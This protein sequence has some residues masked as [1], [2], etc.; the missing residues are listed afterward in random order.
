MFVISLMDMA[1]FEKI[2]QLKTFIQVR[3]EH[4]ITFSVREKCRK[5]VQGYA[6]EEAI[7]IPGYKKEE[8]MKQYNLNE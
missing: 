3:E 4:F 8:I 6:M 2:H 7:R 5:S 1:E